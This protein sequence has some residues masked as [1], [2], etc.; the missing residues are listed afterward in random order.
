MPENT[1]KLREIYALI[2]KSNEPDSTFKQE[3]FESR[4]PRLMVWLKD[5]KQKGKLIACGGGAFENNAGGLTLINAGSIDEAIEI[6]AGTPMNEIGKTEIMI[7][8][9]YY[10]NLVE[11]KQEEKLNQ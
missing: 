3:E 4:I 11:L 7:W 8:D 10:G 5:L 1:N 6:S 9:V 2:W